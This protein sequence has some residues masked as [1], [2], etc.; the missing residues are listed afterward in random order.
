[1]AALS[2]YHQEPRRCARIERIQR[3]VAI[4]VFDSHPGQTE[5]E[6]E[7][8][9]AELRDTFHVLERCG[10]RRIVDDDLLVDVT[11]IEPPRQAV[12][13]AI[14]FNDFLRL[15]MI[16]REPGVHVVQHERATRLERSR[17]VPDYL[18]VICRLF[19]VTEARKQTEHEIEGTSAERPPHVAAQEAEALV[20][21]P[22]CLTDA[23]GRQVKSCH[24]QSERRQFSGMASCPA[25]EVERTQR[26]E[27]AGLP[28]PEPLDQALDE[29][30]GFLLVTKG[31]EPVIVRGIEP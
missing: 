7:V 18:Q 19:E 31:I 20:F 23:L 29:L 6:A 13:H 3:V 2:D 27:W 28:R 12:D 24:F 16:L 25:A 8:A 1:M 30:G 17:D 11:R 9:E 4:G 5:H 21:R 22:L 10:R 14:P 15:E 26:F